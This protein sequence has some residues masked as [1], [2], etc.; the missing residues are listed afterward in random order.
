VTFTERLR[1][2]SERIDAAAA[3]AGRTGSE[4]TLVAVSKTFPAHCVREALAAGVTDFGENRAQELQSKAAEIGEGPRWHFVGH[5]Q[6]NKVRAVVGAAALVHSVDRMDLAEAI[7]RRAGFLG[8]IQDVLVQVN[9]AGDPAKHGAAPAQALELASAAAELGNVE[10]R[11]LMTIPP[12]PE[13]PEGSRRPYAAL[14]RLG[15]ALAAELGRPVELSMGMTRD[16]E[17]AIEEGATLV[18]VGEALFGARRV[19]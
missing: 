15:D 1:E 2:L 8:V 14:A 17:I 12:Y 5:L 18:R 9:V 16:F 10:V 4:V 11:G 6:S 7:D 3:H 13:D 19:P